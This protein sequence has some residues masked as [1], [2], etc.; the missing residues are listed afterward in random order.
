[1]QV[2]SPSRLRDAIAEHL[3]DGMTR[4][5]IE[6]FFEDLGLAPWPDEWVS[7]TKAAFVWSIL[8]DHTLPELADVAR[9][10]LDEVEAPGLA[11]LVD[12]LGP[13]GVAGDLKNL[14]FAADGP[15]PKIVFR[16][17]VNNDIALVENE[18]YCLVYDRPLG[19]NGLTW[20]ELT[21]WWTGREGL[22][23]RSPAE[24]SRSLYSRLDRSLGGNDAERRILRTYADRYVRLGSGIPA[25]IPQVYLHYDP[26]T[27]RQGGT[28]LARQRMDF[29][30]LLPNRARVVIECDGIQHYADDLGRASPQRY[31]EMVAEDRGLR[32]RGYEV[33]RFGGQELR[34]EARP[35]DLLRTFFDALAARHGGGA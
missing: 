1:M 32:L 11:A 10:V 17:A 18:Q 4:R 20:Q 25:L 22:T 14:I 29:L 8:G 31:A 16:D 3:R 21:D 9:R 33:Y 12:R 24:V 28:V 7:L 15:K 34:E 23:G 5:Q 27:K 30:L 19:P 35:G 2:V 13:T 26:Y 6:N